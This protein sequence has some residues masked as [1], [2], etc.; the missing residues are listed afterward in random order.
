ML[1]QDLFKSLDTEFAKVTKMDLEGKKDVFNRVFGKGY[2]SADLAA[3][4]RHNLNLVMR[5]TR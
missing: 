2:Q 3:A 1:I 5:C 4:I